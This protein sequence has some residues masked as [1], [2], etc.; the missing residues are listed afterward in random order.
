MSMPPT[1]EAM[2][3]FKLL[4]IDSNSCAVWRASSRVGERTRIRGSLSPA[5]ISFKSGRAKARVF[6]DPV[7]ACTIR[8]PSRAFSSERT[9]SWTGVG[10]LN[11]LS[12]RAAASSGLSL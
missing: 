9:F 11:P 2:R 5:S 6:P 3:I 1:R 10:V 4:A 8:S 7:L 12:A